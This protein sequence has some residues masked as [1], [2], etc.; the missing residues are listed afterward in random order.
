MTI[1]RSLLKLFK[2][3]LNVLCPSRQMKTNNA[4]FLPD[5]D[6]KTIDNWSFLSVHFWGENPKGEWILKVSLG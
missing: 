4:F 3:I 5:K 1:L 2:S 6:N